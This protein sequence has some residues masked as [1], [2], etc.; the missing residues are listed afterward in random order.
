MLRE[1][2][3]A[4]IRHPDPMRVGDSGRVLTLIDDPMCDRLTKGDSV[5]GWEGDERLALYLDMRERT[6]DLWRM[7][8]D[9][10]Y[11][12][13]MRLSADVWRGPEVVAEMVMRLIGSDQRRGVKVLDVVER[14][15]K[16]AEAASEA[17]QSEWVGEA[18][19]RLAHG[20]IKDGVAS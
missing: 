3:V 12:P 9:G 4:G 16:K 1:H 8:G 19:D 5:F 18:A 20:L 15:A 10:V 7:E 11:R 2:S 6:W 13:T 17:R 14:A